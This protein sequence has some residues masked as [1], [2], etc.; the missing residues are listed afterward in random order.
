MSALGEL[1]E[2]YLATRVIALDRQDVDFDGAQILV[3][4]SKFDWD[5]L[6]PLHPSSI[7]ALKAYA[8]R[9]DE[10]RAVCRAPSFLVS[11]VGT[12]LSYG[13]VNRIFAALTGEVGLKPSGMAAGPCS[14][15]SGTALRSRHCWAGTAQALMSWRK[16]R[17]CRPSCAI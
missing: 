13:C 1:A 10:L 8:C 9:R 12:R 5:R 2:D 4:S 16:S 6:L 15:T 7:I 3:R 11:I 14:M 17:S